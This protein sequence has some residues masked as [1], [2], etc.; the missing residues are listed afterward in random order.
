MAT[1][2]RAVRINRPPSEQTAGE[3]TN[4]SFIVSAE[5]WLAARRTAERLGSS[6]TTFAISFTEQ[7]TA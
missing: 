6:R 2:I 4:D 7:M 3:N 1:I 5:A